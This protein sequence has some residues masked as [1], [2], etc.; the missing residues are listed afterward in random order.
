MAAT[1][2]LTS[3]DILPLVS[4]KEAIDVIEKAFKDFSAGHYVMPLRTVTDFGADELSLF[5]KP[6]WLPSEDIVSVKLLSQLKKNHSKDIPTIRGLIILTNPVTNSVKAILDG[7]SLT[8]VRTGAASGVATRHLA[9]EDSKVLAVFGG[10][11]QGYTQFEAVCCERNITDAFIYDIN[12]ETAERFAGYFKDKSSCNIQ[13]AHDLSF[14]P[15]ADIICTAT[16]SAEPLFPVELL[17][18]GVHINAV[19]SYNPKMQELPNELFA[20]ALLY[21]DHQESC[22]SES[23][24]LIK[25]LKQGT[26]N[27]D[28]YR[29]EI[30]S[31]VASEIKGRSSSEEITIFK[32]VG[33]AIQ[34]LAIADYVYRKSVELGCG[35][36]F[37]F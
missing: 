33:I 4:M 30:G 32:S 27:M 31:L 17:K 2:I 10:G 7:A 3:R 19:G 8:A 6:C 34:D 9:R 11:T 23:G 21:V 5:Y 22:F 18:P 14:L 20:K 37:E 35:N 12:R 26:L 28:N 16:P 13:V 1:K 15:L 36:D 29:G 24:D 25:P